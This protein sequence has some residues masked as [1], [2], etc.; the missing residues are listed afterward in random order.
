MGIMFQHEPRAPYSRI[1]IHVRMLDA[2]NAAQAEALG[3]VGVNLVYGAGFLHHDPEELLRSLLD[4]LSIGRIEIDM[5]E[6]KGAAFEG[7]DNRLMSLRL[8]QMGLSGAAMFGPKGDVLQPSEVLYRKAILVERGAFHPVTKVH[9]DML[10]CAARKFRAL[11][12]VGQTPVVE[13]MEITMRNLLSEQTEFDP[14]DFLD[15]ADVL[16]ACG[17]TVLVSDFSEYYRLGAFLARMTKEPIGIALGVT[18]LVNLFDENF[19]QSLPGGILES[20]GR[21]LKN[22]LKLFVY[23]SLHKDTGGL[24]SVDN[25]QMPPHLHKLYEYLKERGSFIGL[26]DC[27]RSLLS[28][29]PRDVLEALMKRD[30]KWKTL[31]PA[32][33]I[34]AIETKGLFL[35]K[36]EAAKV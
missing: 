22:N 33:V 24:I 9:M 30:P 28:I 10:H 2:E 21:L 27:D 5:I 15:R 6:F 13:I 16:A 3:V 11:P 26:D 14:K 8:V 25:V 29:Y 18:R 31:V 19:Y 35:P 12:E 34:E 17:L 20:F 7:V 32:E 1:L 4:Q 36:Q 23:P